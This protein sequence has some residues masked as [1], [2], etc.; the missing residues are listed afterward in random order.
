MPNIN[1]EIKVK[2]TAHGKDILDKDVENILPIMKTCISDK[3]YYPYHVDKDGYIKFQLWNFMRIFGSH[4]WNGC[5]QV[6][7]NNE[8]IFIP[9]ITQAYAQNLFDEWVAYEERCIK[10]HSWRFLGFMI[11]L[12]SVKKLSDYQIEEVIKLIDYMNNEV[13]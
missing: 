3:T 8:I 2:L 4:F 6:I 10:E 1:D 5:P 12:G 9:E 11:W 13:E 7:E